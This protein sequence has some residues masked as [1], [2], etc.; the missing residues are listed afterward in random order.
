MAE[1][2]ADFFLTDFHTDFHTDV[3]TDNCTERGAAPLFGR[4][5]GSPS[6]SFSRE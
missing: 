6:A 3:F 1:P 2:E 4:T 5:A